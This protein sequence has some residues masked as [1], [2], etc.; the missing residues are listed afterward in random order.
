VGRLQGYKL[1]KVA[2]VCILP[3]LLLTACKEESGFRTGSKVSNAYVNPSTVKEVPKEDIKAKGFEYEYE[4]LIYELV[5]GDEFE[6]EGLP[7]DTKWNYD[8]GGH[9]WGN[10]ELQYYTSDKNATVKDGNLII[11]AKRKERIT[12]TKV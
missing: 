4:N 8:V 6:Y 12:I 5:W 1:L 10:N 2:T 11:E 7:D 3:C 9:G